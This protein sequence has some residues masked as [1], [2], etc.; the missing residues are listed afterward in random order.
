MEIDAVEDM[1]VTKKEINPTQGLRANVFMCVTKS[2][3]TKYTITMEI[4]VPF[5][6]R[7][8]KYYDILQKGFASP[9]SMPFS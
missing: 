1:C 8:L 9:V 5:F 3:V 4:N 7:V 2:E 6:V